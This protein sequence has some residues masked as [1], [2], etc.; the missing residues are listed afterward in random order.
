[1]SVLS[2]SFKR[3]LPVLIRALFA[4][5]WRGDMLGAHPLVLQVKRVDAYIPTEVSCLNHLIQTCRVNIKLTG[6]LIIL[7]RDES[8]LDLSKALC[9]AGLIIIFGI[10]VV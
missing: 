1:M 7:D 8:F 3:V 6:L 2:L 10:G 4:P 9:F 5:P